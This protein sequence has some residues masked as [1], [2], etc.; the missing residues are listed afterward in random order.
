M[1]I[2]IVFNI[3][4]VE[5]HLFGSDVMSKKV[6]N[7]EVKF[8]AFPV[9]PDPEEPVLLQ[10]SVLDREN[11]NV[12]NTEAS[13][14]IMKNGDTIFT[15]PKIK[16]E[17]SDFYMQYTFPENGQ[18]QIMLEASIPDEPELLRADFMLNVGR[19]N[20]SGTNEF[21]IYAVIGGVA[22]VVAAGLFLRRV[23]STRSIGE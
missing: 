6:G 13:V 18:Y 14:K 23:K 5:G 22:A 16:Y 9:Y 3:N 11:N 10:F 21:V 8:L 7:Y 17:I 12:W 2:V 19:D 15:W 4:L 1:L 20:N